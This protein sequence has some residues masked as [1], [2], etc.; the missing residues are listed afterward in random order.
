[1]KID[2]T[3]GPI[4]STD[5]ALTPVQAKLTLKKLDLSQSALVDPELGITGSA[6]FD[7]PL[8][9]DDH[10]AK[11]NG[12]VKASSLNFPRKGPPPPLPVHVAFPP[13][14]PPHHATPTF[15]P[16]HPP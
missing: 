6:D 15:S 11:A 13:H 16:A 9:S 12:T 5:T 2:G 1:M 14:P 8:T 7:G 3:A 4:N 10:I